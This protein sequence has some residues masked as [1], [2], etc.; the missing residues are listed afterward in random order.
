MSNDEENNAA[1]NTEFGCFANRTDRAFDLRKSFV[2]YNQIYLLYIWH[3][4]DKH[5]LMKTSMQ[6]SDYSVSAHNGA[7]EVPNVI[8]V[9]SDTKSFHATKKLKSIQWRPKCNN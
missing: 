4:L 6:Q 7:M 8:N 1:T 2:L 3:M 5:D 9:R